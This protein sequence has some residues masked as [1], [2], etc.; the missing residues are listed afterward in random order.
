MKRRF[1][2]PV[3]GLVTSL[4]L[5]TASAMAREFRMFQVP[6]GPSIGCA[7][8]HFSPGGGG[9]RNPFGRNVEAITGPVNRPFWTLALAAKDS[10]GDG[11]GNGVELGDP[12]GDSTIIA[13]WLATGPGDASSK[14]VATGFAAWQTQHF[15]LPDEAALAEALVDADGDGLLNLGEYTLGRDPRV[16]DA[17]VSVLP[18]VS[19]NGEVALEVVVRDDDPKL[20]ISLEA[21][22]DAAYS[23]PQ[24]I[25]ASSTTPGPGDGMQTLRF[26]DAVPAPVGGTHRFWRLR[27][28]LNP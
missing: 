11:S 28:E 15:S 21:A 27:I 7:L 19:A 4:V 24:T 22:P 8:C 9:P 18:Q 6:N 5:L 10:D 25:T 20:V 26:A 16:P 23:A 3:F 1:C 14:P 17:P 2:R 12:E 13:G